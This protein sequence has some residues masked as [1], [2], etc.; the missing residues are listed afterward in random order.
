M[1]ATKRELR[2]EETVSLS[3]PQCPDCA[4][5]RE[6]YREELHALK[7]LWEGHLHNIA[8][9]SGKDSWAVDAEL[10]RIEEMLQ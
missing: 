2:P 5:L 6:R 8:E 10:K 3:Q 7:L 4:Y 9:L 1:S